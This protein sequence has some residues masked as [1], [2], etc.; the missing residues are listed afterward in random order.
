MWARVR[1]WARVCVC[2]HVCVYVGTC[3]RMWAYAAGVAIREGKCAR[4]AMAEAGDGRR[5]GLG[6]LVGRNIDRGDAARLPA[7]TLGLCEVRMR[8][9]SLC[10]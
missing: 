1:M 2:G 8:C 6:L 7:D 3:V 4:Q 5:F 10:A 9:V